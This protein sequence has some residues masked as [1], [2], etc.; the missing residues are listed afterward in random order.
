MLQCIHHHVSQRQL[1][2]LA[3]N[4]QSGIIDYQILQDKTF[5]VL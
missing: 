3:V 1:R 2:K 4:M 5:Y